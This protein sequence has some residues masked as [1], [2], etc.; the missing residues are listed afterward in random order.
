[1]VALCTLVHSGR[2]N[3]KNTTDISKRN[4]KHSLQQSMLF[5]FKEQK[6]NSLNTERYTENPK[7]EHRYPRYITSTQAMR[8]YTQMRIPTHRTRRQIG[9]SSAAVQYINIFMYTFIYK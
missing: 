9:T 5:S 7:G 1:M 6:G 2:E 4:S 8:G 3:R